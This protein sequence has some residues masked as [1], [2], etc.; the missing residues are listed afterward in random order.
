MPPHATG[1]HYRRSIEQVVAPFAEEFAPTWLVLSAGYDGH[2]RD[3]LTD[4]ALTSGDFADITAD[5]LQLVAPGRRLVLL[6]GGYDLHAVADSSAAT[7]A[8]LLG[9]RLHPEAPSSGGP[10]AGV[11][12]AVAELRRQL[13]R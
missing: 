5:L 8:A 12:S 7:I 13:D 9:E 6:E 3:P 2:R 11:V 1:E 4:L 10:G